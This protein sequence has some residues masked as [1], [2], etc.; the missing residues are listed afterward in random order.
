MGFVLHSSGVFPNSELVLVLGKQGMN[1]VLGAGLRAPGGGVAEWDVAAWT[2][3]GPLEALQSPQMFD[4][5]SFLVSFFTIKQYLKIDR[6]WRL[7]YTTF[8]P[9]EIT[10][11][12]ALRGPG[13]KD[14]PASAFN[15][16][17]LQGGIIGE[18]KTSFTL[19]L[20]ICTNKLCTT[21]TKCETCWKRGQ[22]LHP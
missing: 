17:I 3:L 10:R 5:S 20:L 8:N 15:W 12:F 21:Q 9:F 22:K 16:R 18:Q 1:W 4:S 11:K 7:G 19:P 14:C 6:G 2:P 13:A